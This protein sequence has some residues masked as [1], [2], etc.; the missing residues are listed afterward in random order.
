MIYK[1]GIIAANGWMRINGRYNR[2]DGI[3]NLSEK[4]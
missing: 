3:L 2:S 4:W 1:R